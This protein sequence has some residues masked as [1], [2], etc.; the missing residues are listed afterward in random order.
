MITDYDY[1]A[2]VMNIN[3]KMNLDIEVSHKNQSSSTHLVKF[4][5]GEGFLEKDF[6]F[7]IFFCTFIIHDIVIVQRKIDYGKPMK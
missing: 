2:N 6:L 3:F 5:T 7:T 1:Q 4:F